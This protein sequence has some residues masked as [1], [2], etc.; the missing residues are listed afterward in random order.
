LMVARRLVV[1]LKRPG[2]QSQFSAHLAAQMASE[3][4]IQA[5][6]HW[7]ARARNPMR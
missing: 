5:V 3:S 7:L 4:R 1:F 2:G 6:Q